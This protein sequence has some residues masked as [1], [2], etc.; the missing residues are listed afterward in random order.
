[1]QENIYDLYFFLFALFHTCA[2]YHDKHMDYAAWI[3]SSECSVLINVHVIYSSTVCSQD[4][5]TLSSMDFILY[6]TRP[7]VKPAELMLGFD[8]ITVHM[9]GAEASV[10]Y[11]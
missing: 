5:W 1:M 8:N 3:R 7:L 4:K 6:V 2:L 11:L 9:L 10:S